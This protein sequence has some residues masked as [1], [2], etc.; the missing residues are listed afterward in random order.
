[1][2]REERF[3]IVRL[4]ANTIVSAK[5]KPDRREHGRRRRSLARLLLLDRGAHRGRDRT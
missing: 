5:F 4:Q 1:M 3:T 2:F